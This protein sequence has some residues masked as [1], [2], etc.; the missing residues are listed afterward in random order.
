[1]PRLPL[2]YH[3]I[4]HQF[5]F[6]IDKWQNFCVISLNSK[7]FSIKM[8]H[9]PNFISYIITLGSMYRKSAS[10]MDKGKVKLM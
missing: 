7:F 4:H 6:D 8:L 5:S 10:G 3:E 9:F 1:M 2:T